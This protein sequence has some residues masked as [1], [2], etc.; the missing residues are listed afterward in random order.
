MH[1]NAPAEITAFSPKIKHF[2][3]FFGGY[4]QHLANQRLLLGGFARVCQMVSEG[5]LIIC[6]K[7]GCQKAPSYD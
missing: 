7:K 1:Q 4:D 3:L 2:C 6:H 5:F